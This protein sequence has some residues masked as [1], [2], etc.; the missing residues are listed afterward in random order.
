M[1]SVS[2]TE[3]GKKEVINVCDGSRYGFVCDVEI[4]IE[5]ARITAIIVPKSYGFLKQIFKKE[6]YVIPWDCIARIGPDIILVN[7][8]NKTLLERKKRT[9]FS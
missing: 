8:Q 6:H 1:N 4:C 5:D 9:W 2:V 7:Y 3:L